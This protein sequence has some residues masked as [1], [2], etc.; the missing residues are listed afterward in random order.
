VIEKD[1]YG[2]ALK[3]FEEVIRGV[4]LPTDEEIAQNSPSRSAKLRAVSF[5]P[6]E[7]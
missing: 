7:G 2:H 5:Q 4:Q 6:M 3:P 1:F